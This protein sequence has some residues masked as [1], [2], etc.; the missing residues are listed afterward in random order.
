[1]SNAAFPETLQL[2]RVA[3]S[4]FFG[5]ALWLGWVNGLRRPF[6]IDGAVGL[7]S[8]SLS[9][10]GV[11]ASE[12]VSRTLRGVRG[13][14]GRPVSRSS[15]ASCLIGVRRKL[16][17]VGTGSSAMS[18][19]EECLCVLGTLWL[20]RLEGVSSLLGPG[21]GDDGRAASAE[22]ERRRSLV[23]WPL[24]FMGLVVFAFSGLRM[25]DPCGDLRV[26]VPGG[27]SVA[28]LFC[29]M[30]LALVLVTIFSG[31]FSL[32]LGVS[33]SLRPRVRKEIFNG[34]AASDTFSCRP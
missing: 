22:D 32:C 10:G 5:G 34:V 1:M 9:V 7:V 28:A 15:V 21:T 30:L 31:V 3:K 29:L 11:S 17:R 33:D 6:R 26:R 20:I 23:F 8:A 13:S 12:I 24:A 4:N 16:R 18:S 27:L 2:R 14:L 19:D 25:G